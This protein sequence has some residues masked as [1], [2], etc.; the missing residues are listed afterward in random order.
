MLIDFHTHVFP[1]EIAERAING[2]VQASQDIYGLD[3]V[4]CF[5]AT[6]NS[7]KSD[8]VKKNIDISV[9]LPIATKPKQHLSINRFAKEITKDNII[10][11]ASV[12]PYDEDISSILQHI[13]SE[14]FA[15]IKLHPDYQNVFVDDERMISLV[16]AAGELGLYSVLHA[17]E[18][19]GI[20]APFHCSVDRLRTFLDGVDESLVVLAHMGGFNIWDG[21]EEYIINSPAYFDTAV[22]SSYID[23][24]QYKRIIDRHG[25]D[26]ILFGSD[27]PWEDP[28]DTLAFLERAGLSDEEKEQIKHKNAKRILKI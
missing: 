1:N 3:R 25:A 23:I 22:V 2:I 28:V 17:G 7:L 16:K 21:V 12:H 14:G 6:V 11:F 27:A 15:G 4:V 24:E 9:V 8:M 18:D 13:N 26:K 20:R 19:L 10:S 5:D